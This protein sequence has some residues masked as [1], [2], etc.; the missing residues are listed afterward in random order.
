MVCRQSHTK[1]SVD[2]HVIDSDK[3]D[4]F[5]SEPKKLG[6]F[7]EVPYYDKISTTSIIRQMVFKS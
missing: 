4:D 5:F 3:Q 6:K 7:M 1:L 2:K